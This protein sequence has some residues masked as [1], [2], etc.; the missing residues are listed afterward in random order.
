MTTTHPTKAKDIVRNWHFIDANTQVLGRLSTQIAL[1]L[2]GKQKP[3][4]V[5]HLDC[6]DYVVVVN[7]KHIVTTGKK[8]TQKLYTQYSGYPA[9]LKAYTLGKLREENPEKIS[10]HAVSGMLPNNKLR[11]KMLTRLFVFPTEEHTY[12]DKF[13]SSK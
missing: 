7:A 1:L 5:R 13:K 12:K 6:G 10:T 4:F 2:M 3:Y 11:D 9:G 8:D